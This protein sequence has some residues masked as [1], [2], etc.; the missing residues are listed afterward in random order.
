VQAQAQAENQFHLLQA[1]CLIHSRLGS[2]AIWKSLNY[3][4]Q[5][6]ILVLCGGESVVCCSDGGVHRRGY[7]EASGPTLG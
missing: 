4:R 7:G 2:V 6:L 1:L 3:L 5:V